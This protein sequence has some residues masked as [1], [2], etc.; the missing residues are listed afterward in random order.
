MKKL[1]IVLLLS[2]I[3]LSVSIVST[4]NNTQKSQSYPLD[5][6][7]TQEQGAGSYVTA[8]S[9]EE[10]SQLSDLIVIGHIESTDQEVNMA[11]KIDN[12]K[13]PD[14]YNYIIGHVYS[15][16]IDETLKGNQ[17]SSVVYLV[18]PE[19]YLFELDPKDDEAKKQAHSRANYI[20]PKK[21]AS[22][23]I[24]LQTLLGFPDGY[25]AQA[26]HPG[27][28]LILDDGNIQPES[29]WTESLI[30]FSDIDINEAKKEIQ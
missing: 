17:S 25:Y 29:I 22:Y 1:A 11:R 21:G 30:Y 18:Q 6:K 12:V 24:F 28:F 2:I 16:T 3:I 14:P 4:R 5:I 20:E 7:G 8:T 26:P 27:R 9:I 13:E 10:L 23:L 15:L 19:G